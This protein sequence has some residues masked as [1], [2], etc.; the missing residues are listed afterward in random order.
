MSFGV[1]VGVTVTIPFK[2]RLLY[3]EYNQSKHLNSVIKSL[4]YPYLPARVGKYHSQKQRQPGDNNGEVNQ[5]PEPIS[6]ANEDDRN[7]RLKQHRIE[8]GLEPRI[9]CSEEGREI[10]FFSSD[11]N[12]PG[13]C[14][15]GP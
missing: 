7:S 4:V 2:G 8:R 1:S 3:P 10:T 14:E 15:E 5:R 6:E 11:I 9:K 13:G 12:E